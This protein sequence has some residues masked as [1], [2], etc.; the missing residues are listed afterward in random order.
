MTYDNAY[1]LSNPKFFELA[2]EEGWLS[3]WEAAA[4]HVRLADYDLMAGIIKSVTEYDS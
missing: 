4:E 1:K 3:D 2:C